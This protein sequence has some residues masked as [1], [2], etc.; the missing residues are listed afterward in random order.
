MS[1][2][3]VEL[4]PPGEILEWNF[5]IYAPANIDGDRIED[6][7]ARVGVLNTGHGIDEGAPPAVVSGNPWSQ[8]GVVLRHPSPVKAAGVQHNS[9]IR[10][11]T[12]WKCLGRTIPSAEAET[13]HNIHRIC[14]THTG[15]NISLGNELGLRCGWEQH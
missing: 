13:I 6:C 15:V 1:V 5:A 10:P 7:A 3:I 4:Q 11:V 2:Y 8:H 12:K 9:E 14:I